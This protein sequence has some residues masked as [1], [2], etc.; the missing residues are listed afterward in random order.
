[1]TTVYVLNK[2]LEVVGVVDEYVS[3]IWRPAY[4]EIGDF[5]LYIGASTAMV[6]LLQLNRYVVRNQD[7]HVINGNITYTN[8][9]IIKGIELITDVENG[10]FLIVRGRELKYLA[11]QRIVW[12]QTVLSGTV[13]DG[14]RQLI[15]ENAIAP[16][17]A[18]RVIPR[19]ALD[20]PLGLT[21]GIEK[22]ITGDYLDQCISEI[23][24]TYNYG[25]TVYIYNDQLLF[26][27]FLGADRTFNQLERPYVVFSDDYENLSNTDYQLTT[28]EYA[29][30]TLIGGEGEGT[31]RTYT[32]VGNSRVGLDRY[33]TFTDARDLSSNTGTEEAIPPE[34]YIE[35]LQERG[36]DSLA[37][38]SYTEGFSGEVLSQLAFKYGVDFFLGDL[39]T[40]INKYGISKDVRV[41]SCIESEDST[42]YKL[43]PQFNI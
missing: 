14:I 43:L 36:K 37:E 16:S 19:L 22:Q 13:E 18:N 24:L 26:T 6:S 7:V 3:L 9:M 35:L 39:V 17:D 29:N 21:D 11:H 10:D 42:G 8:V 23:C 32:T 5:E 28:E 15:T 27:L 30:C 33:E 4:S 25:W 34:Q 2:D 31:E 40:V 41:I 1:M 12:E 38:R 20:T